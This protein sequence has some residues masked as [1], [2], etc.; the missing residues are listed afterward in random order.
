MKKEKIYSICVCLI[1]LD[2]ITKLIITL[3]M[4]VGKSIEV[5]PN[6]FEIL[7]LRNTGAAFSLLENMRYLFIFV[8][9][10]VF[11]ILYKYIE[12]TKIKSK[13]EIL[14]L[15]LILGGLVGNL[16]DRLLYGYVIDFLS[17]NIFGYSF[18]V[19][20]VAD[21]GIVV[22]VFILIISSFREEFLKFRKKQG[23]KV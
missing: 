18:P 17:F 20:N 21:I 15:G 16:V 6:F 13:S 3:K 1:L 7:Y 14:S 22:G 23:R 12:K 9:M 19:F 11:F 2:Q 4:A 8:S 10:L 5:I